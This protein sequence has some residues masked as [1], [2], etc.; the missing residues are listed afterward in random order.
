MPKTGSKRVT[1]FGP[2]RVTFGA[3]KS[4]TFR[5]RF[6]HSKV[7]DFEIL[8]VVCPHPRTLRPTRVV[9]IKFP[10]EHNLTVSGGRDIL[11][12]RRLGELFV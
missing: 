8:E 3:K 5:A 2:K 10:K 7:P 6:E 9:I 12:Q 1:F 4:D 11:S